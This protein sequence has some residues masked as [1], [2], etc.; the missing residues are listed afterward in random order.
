M[1]NLTKNKKNYLKKLT[2]NSG[3]IN[4]LAI[5][6]RGSLKKMLG[7]TGGNVEQTIKKFKKSV[8]KELTPYASAILLDP[9]Y[10]W[11]A[12]DTKDNKTG[13]LMA[14]EE[15]GYD[16]SEEGRLPDLLPNYSVKRLKENGV[17]A[18][19][20]LLYY[21]KDEG[22]HI[23][24]IKKAF[25]ERVGS[26]CIG[27]D[28]PFFLE[29][30]TYDKYIKDVK[31]TEYAKI[32]PEKV[33]ESMREFSNERYNVDVLKVEVPVNMNFVEGYSDSEYVHTKQEAKE[34]FKAQS[35]A[36]N[37]PF[38]FLSAGV[39]IDLFKKTLILAGESGSKFN[40]VLCGRATWKDS[41]EIFTDQGEEQAKIW[42]Q[43]TGK[44]NVVDLDTIL[45]NHATPIADLM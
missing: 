41:V 44:I 24:D 10:G 36:T 25:V 3:I 22:E 17:D 9:E 11:D 4:A 45:K 15:T 26:E 19:K 8:S 38:I 37:L 7:K 13:L 42:L 20:I 27:E 32:K 29:I 34:Y 40:G 16:A 21:D 5:D 35:E 39:T 33:I 30:V 1:S 23:N 2:T 14:Y 18:I 31:G 6:Q 28:I 43:T 12:V